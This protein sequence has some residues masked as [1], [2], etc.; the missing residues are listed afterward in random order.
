MD[1]TENYSWYRT[2]L[3]SVIQGSKKVTGT[4]TEWLTGGIKQGDALIINGQFNEIDKVTG[5]GV[6][7]LVK[8]YTG[9]TAA[10]LEYAIIP[11]ARAVLLAELAVDIKKAVT[12]WNNRDKLFEEKIKDLEKSASTQGV[13]GKL[14]IYIDDDGDLAQ[15]DEHIINPDDSDSEAEKDIATED[16]VDEM[17]D[18]VFN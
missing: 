12:Y 16:D 6:L 1:F 18:D 4:N 9:E 10:S 8:E 3:I 17:L 13:F 11:R 7:T 15:D 5:S 2:G 14:G